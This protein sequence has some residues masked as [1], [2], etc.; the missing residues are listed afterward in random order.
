MRDSKNFKERRQGRH[1]GWGRSTLSLSVALHCKFIGAKVPLWEPRG[2]GGP[3]EDTPTCSP[4]AAEGGDMVWLDPAGHTG[5]RPSRQTRAGPTR[6]TTRRLGK[7]GGLAPRASV[8]FGPGRA[9]ASQASS[10][11]P[12]SGLDVRH[13]INKR[14]FS[15]RLMSAYPCHKLSPT[16]TEGF[17][18]CVSREVSVLPS[19]GTG[20][21]LSSL[22][23]VGGGN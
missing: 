23:G 7:V 18:A 8:Q 20:E 22:G 10:A 3:L 13:C 9:A 17:Q 1:L 14:Y 19:T 15:L 12:L 2:K 16:C 6:P 11:G 21:L 4:P 5:G